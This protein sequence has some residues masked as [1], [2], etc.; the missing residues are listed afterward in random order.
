MRWTGDGLDEKHLCYWIKQ[1]SC[2]RFLRAALRS[3]A[4]EQ[5]VKIR[6]V[7]RREDDS[8]KT[9]LDICRRTTKSA[10]NIFLSREHDDHYDHMIKIY[11]IFYTIYLIMF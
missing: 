3:D 11:S 5:S 1:K 2:K 6:R 9:Q 8:Q 7:K 4:G 10:L